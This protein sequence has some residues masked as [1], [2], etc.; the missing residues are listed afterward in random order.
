MD[1]F[2]VRICWEDFFFL[3]LHQNLFNKIREKDKTQSSNVMMQDVWKFY[4]DQLNEQ[5]KEVFLD[6]VCY[7]KSEDEYFVRSILD[8]GNPDSAGA[9]SEVTDLANKFLITISDSRIEMNDLVYTFGK[10]LRP[11]RRYRLWEY[12]DIIN[13]LGKMG[14]TVS[15]FIY[16]IYFFC[17][18]ENSQLCL[19]HLA[20]DITFAY[21]L[22]HI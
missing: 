21:V 4:I 10:Y 5:Q 3:H 22:D 14:E 18:G 9:V 13:K 16:H 20:L 12:E 1:L 8:S 19:Q 7:F 6:I 11:P 2:F 17:R 15:Y